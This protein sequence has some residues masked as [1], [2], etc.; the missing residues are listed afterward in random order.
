MT[1][2]DLQYCVHAISLSK[3]YYFHPLVIIYCLDLSNYFIFV[4]ALL[5]CIHIIKF[6]TKVKVYSALRLL[7]MLT[8]YLFLIGV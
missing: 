5:H 7:G 1:Y 3:S 4:P 2:S 8:S 6:G